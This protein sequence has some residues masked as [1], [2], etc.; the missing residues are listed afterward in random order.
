MNVVSATILRNHLAE[1]LSQVQEKDYLLVARRGQITSALVN[2]DLLEDL[3]ALV[4][5]KYL[6]SIRKARREYQ[7]GGVF[8][9]QQVFGQV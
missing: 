7:Q 3:L 2:I 8:T 9:H 1:T 4:N 6:S 5:N